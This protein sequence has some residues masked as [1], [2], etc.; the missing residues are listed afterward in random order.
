MPKLSLGR[1]AIMTYLRMGSPALWRTIVRLSALCGHELPRA[2]AYGFAQCGQCEQSRRVEQG[3]RRSRLIEDERQF[4]TREHGGIAAVVF[5]VEEDA[6]QLRGRLRIENA[7]NEFLHDCTVDRESRLGRG[8]HGLD[9]GCC[10]TLGIDG[11]FDEVTR[12]QDAD[13]PEAS[14]LRLRSD[15]IGYME[16][17]QRRLRCDER[18]RL[19]D[20]IVGANEEP[21]SGC[22][23]FMCRREHEPCDGGHVARLKRP[24]VIR[25]RVRVHRYFGMRVRAEQR[26]AF[27]AYRAKA[28]RG[29]FGGAC[30]DAD[31]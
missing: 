28:Q 23:E 29:A 16:P 12:S 24:N 4:R 10:K 19:M 22:R 7:V 11:A 14:L 9:P 3:Q 2:I 30:N 5:Q 8:S 25:E 17:R 21:G 13:T 18:K 15:C 20:G 6:L 31:M 27:R 1:I 26:C